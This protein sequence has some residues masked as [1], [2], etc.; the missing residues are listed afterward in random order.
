MYNIGRILSKRTSGAGKY[1]KRWPD[2]P[3][4]MVFGPPNV[5]VNKLSQRLAIDLGVPVI[6]MEQEFN[7]VKQYAGTTEEYDHPFYHKVKEILESGDQAY[8]TREK[9]G[10]K[11]LRI[12]EYAQEGFI[13]NDYPH[14][15]AD[16]ESLEEMDGGMNSFLH[17]NMPEVF[18]AQMES[19]KY[20][21]G[22]CHAIYWR[23]DVFDAETGTTQT[24]NYPDD[25]FCNDCGS[26]HIKPATDPELF[27][28]NLQQY[29]DKKDEILE[30]YNHLGLLVDIDVRKGGL[31]DYERV[32]QKLQFGIKF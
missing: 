7:N 20:E 15:L 1:M 12:S 25:G 30:F 31:E 18:L 10:V 8:I 11:L 32:K 2:K 22:D 19:S 14:C 24:S 17:L 3:K 9:L 23:D 29:N 6:S 5:P 4:V 27:E 21:C 28:N 13:L 26:I 16:A